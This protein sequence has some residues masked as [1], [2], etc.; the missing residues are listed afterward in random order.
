MTN[1]AS[2][3]GERQP[4]RPGGE[5][6]PPPPPYRHLEAP[7]APT[8]ATAPPQPR[9]GQY[10]PGFQTPGPQYGA[11]GHA[12]GHGPG[13]VP[14]YANPTMFAPK[15]GVIPLRPL[16]LGDVLEGAFRTVRGNPG[17]TIGLAFLVSLVFAIPTVL[18]TL[19]VADTAFGASD[20]G[21][22][23]ATLASYASQL[24]GGIASILLSGMLIVVVAE[25]VLGHRA[26]IAEAW[27][28]IRPRI[29]ALLGAT[30]LLVLAVLAAA[31]LLVGLG[32]LVYLGGGEAATIIYALFAALA[33]LV[34]AVW[35]STRLSL[36]PAAITLEGLGPV[37]GLKRSWTLTR[38]QFWRILGITLLAQ[39]LVGAIVGVIMVPALMIAV[40][41]MAA[42]LDSESTSTPVGFLVLIQVL[43]I[44]SSA[45]TAPFTSS[46]T[47]LLYLDQRIRR[48]AF[49]LELMNAASAE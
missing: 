36:A 6:T 12:P 39:L 31:A 26:T 24:V 43:S 20:S 29:W 13:P 32:I 16:V 46:V 28:R 10:A 37:A 41:V 47:G 38:G 17:A 23:V 4:E 35:V 8:A 3:S 33:F 34:V 40:G 42:S 15:P 9:Y 44:L 49:D 7:A 14:A 2:P 27:Q 48:E 30:C 1:W 25:A 22:V 5:A 19:L 21:D 11:P 45:I 18:V